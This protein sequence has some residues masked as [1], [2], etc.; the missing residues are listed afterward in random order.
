M[1]KE[2]DEARE[3]A[4][5]A[6]NE[7]IMRLGCGPVSPQIIATNAEQDKKAADLAKQYGE[8]MAGIDAETRLVEENVN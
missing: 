8:L 5:N 2:R 4:R 1:R 7:L 3:E 6:I